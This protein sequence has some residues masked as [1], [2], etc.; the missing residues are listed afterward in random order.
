MVTAS[1]PDQWELR[2]R[3]F[4]ATFAAKGVFTSKASLTCLKE[5][6]THA[7]AAKLL[8]VKADSKRIANCHYEALEVLG[9]AVLKSQASLMLYVAHRLYSLSH[10]THVTVFVM[11]RSGSTHTGLRQ[12]DFSAKAD[13]DW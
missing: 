6:L 4:M 10:A 8:A 12:K 11:C 2:V 5:A 1:A 9:D 7:S 3:Q 13:S